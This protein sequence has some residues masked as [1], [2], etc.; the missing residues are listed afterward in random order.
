[1]TFSANDTEENST[2]KAA[3]NSNKYPDLQFEQFYY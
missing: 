1:M 2:V 3:E